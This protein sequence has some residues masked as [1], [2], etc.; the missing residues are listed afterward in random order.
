MFALSLGHKLNA[1]KLKGAP[2]RKSAT[3]SKHYRFGWEITV[4]GVSF[5]HVNDEF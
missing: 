1:S 4:S 5:D 3:N 2:L